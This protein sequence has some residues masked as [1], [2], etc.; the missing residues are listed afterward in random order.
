M[1]F[2]W[3]RS[4]ALWF[5]V[6]GLLFLLWGWWVSMR[7]WSA[8]SYGHALSAWEAG[9]VGGGVYA[10]WDANGWPDKGEMHAGHQRCTPAEARELEKDWSKLSEALPNCRFARITYYQI[11]PGYLAFWAVLLI[12]R[13]LKFEKRLL[14]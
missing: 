8:V 4:R 11:F 12:W 14:E 3:F 6:P 10:H 1:R 13:K 9:Q 2:R 7:H 5:G